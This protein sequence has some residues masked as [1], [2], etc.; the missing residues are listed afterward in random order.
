[1]EL[2]AFEQSILRSERTL[3]SDCTE[4]VLHANPSYREQFLLG[5]NHW[6]ERNQDMRYFSPLG[7]PGLAVGD[8]NGDGLDDLYV[9]QEANLPNRLFLGQS[10]GTAR[11]VSAEWQVDWLESSRSALIVDLDNDGD[12]DLAV[13]VLGGIVVA[14]NEGNRFEVKDVLVTDDDTT[15]L[16]A[17]DYDLDGDLDLYACVDY[18]NDFFS[19]SDRPPTMI[20]A[21]NRVYHD[22]S[23]AGRNSLFRNDQQ[24]IGAWRF[25][26]VTSEAGLDENNRRFSWAACWEDF[27]NDGDPDLYVANDFGRNNLYLNEHGRF[28]DV[29]AQANVEDSASGMSAAWGDVDRDGRMD[30]YVGNMF[31]SAGSRVSFQP[32]FKRDAEQQ[33][34]GRIQRFA[35]GSSLF[36]NLDG[37]EFRDVSEEAH[38]T[39]GRWSWSSNFI[40][41]NNDGWQDIAV[42]NGYMT[43][44]DSSDL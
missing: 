40:D 37:N 31:S 25:T 28:R 23:D 29:A 3:F 6:L 1:M 16:A 12:Q 5:M 39:L 36:L 4:S 26:D 43:A 13:A 21:A 24:E 2:L 33:V 35:R 32:E 22:A 8:A 14:A 41:I 38:V 20:G 15:S 9:C 19:G 10:D 34:R 17:A 7:N 11:D 18:P 44:S 30:L 27:D 42:A